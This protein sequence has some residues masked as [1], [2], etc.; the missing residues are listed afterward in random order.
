[1]HALVVFVQR[2]RLPNF[3]AANPFGAAEKSGV[4]DAVNR[5]PYQITQIRRCDAT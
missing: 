5:I 3:M 4:Q 2:Q 1:M